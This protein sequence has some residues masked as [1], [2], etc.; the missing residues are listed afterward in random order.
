MVCLTRL[1]I[2]KQVVHRRIHYSLC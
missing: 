2:T 1:N